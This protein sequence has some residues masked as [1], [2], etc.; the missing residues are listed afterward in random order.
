MTPPSADPILR[1][2]LNADSDADADPALSALI[3]PDTDSLIR[4]IVAYRLGGDASAQDCDDIVADVVLHLIERLQALRADAD[5]SPISR[6]QAYVTTAA[7]NGCDAYLRRRYPQRHRLRNRLRYFFDKSEAF[8]TW[9]PGTGATVCG[10]TAWSARPPSRPN[11]ADLAN[12]LHFDMNQP[13]AAIDEVFR[14]CN[15]PM[16]FEELV[17][18]MAGLWAIKDQQQT[19]EDLQDAA[20]A[21]HSHTDVIIDQ[22][23]ALEKLWSEVLELPVA[24]RQALLLNLRD[25]EGGSAIVTLPSTGTASVRKIAAVLEMPPEELA[26]LWGRLPLSDLELAQ[27]MGVTRQQVINLRKSARQRLTRRTLAASGE[28]LR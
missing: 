11:A 3:F 13:E 26:R 10:R 22:R 14:H 8:G 27:R 20:V 19:L 21:P 24:Q 6:F 1:D 5:T 12:I 9:D 7:H 18:I 17:G 28:N 16:E 15:A 4:R 25:S 2:Y 23:R